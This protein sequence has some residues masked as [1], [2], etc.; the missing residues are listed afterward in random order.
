MEGF[1][2][3]GC[4]NC[5]ETT[6]SRKMP[7]AKKEVLVVKNVT[8]IAKKKN[9][10]KGGKNTEL[11]MGGPK[12]RKTKGRRILQQNMNKHKRLHGRE[13]KI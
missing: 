5:K 12:E 6:K 8:R 10:K 4:R 2:N 1:G 11:Q 13:F 7:S 3:S 9:H